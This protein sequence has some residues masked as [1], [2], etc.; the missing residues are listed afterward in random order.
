MIAKNSVVK[1]QDLIVN[2]KPQLVKFNPVNKTQKVMPED[3]LQQ[4]S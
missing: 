3:H 4:E 1:I 2:H